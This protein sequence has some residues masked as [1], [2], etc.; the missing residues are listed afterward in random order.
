MMVRDLAST[1][2]I[3]NMG[4]GILVTGTK[5]KRLPKFR[6]TVVSRMYGDTTAE[7][8][9]AIQKG[10]RKQPPDAA[11]AHRGANVETPHP[12]RFRQGGFDGHA[13]DTNECFVRKGAEQPFAVTR[14][15]DV[16]S[17]PLIDKPADMEMALLSGFV[18]KSRHRLRQPIMEDANIDRHGSKRPEPTSRAASPQ[19]ARRPA[20]MSRPHRGPCRGPYVSPAPSSPR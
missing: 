20:R 2:Q 3:E 13:T 5:F 6:R 12:Q 4:I 19:P 15:A 10:E 14:E 1:A 9:R 7:A 8:P 18:R 11:T 16:A 17:C